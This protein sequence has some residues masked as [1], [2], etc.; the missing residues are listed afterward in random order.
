[1]K[2]NNYTLKEVIF[3]SRE[4]YLKIQRDLEFLR[5]LCDSKD[6]NVK[7]FEFRLFKLRQRKPEIF[8]EFIQNPSTL[9]G[10]IIGLIRIIDKFFESLEDPDFQ[11]GKCLKNNNNE[12]YIMNKYYN[13]FVKAG[14]QKKFA[15]VFEEIL[16]SDFVN[17]INFGHY[18][19]EAKLHGLL[20]A[21]RGIQF[22]N[23]IIE[24]YYNVKNDQIEIMNYRYNTTT[25]EMI[26]EV[27]NFEISKN[28]FSDYHR[29][30]IEKSPAMQKQI[31]YNLEGNN[32]RELNL[33][34]NEK[35]D[36]I[37]LRKVK[38]KY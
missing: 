38:T 5:T 29:T 9:R 25:E 31:V 35:S 27:L 3:G 16:N 2:E 21:V 1:M 24:L 14:K 28:I 6:K 30:I 23:S 37:V 18:P 19:L 22:N 17:K 8:C 36:K 26:N 11:T 12:Y 7:D 33:Y 13:A 32:C 15:M 34:I 4:E 10:N 20:V